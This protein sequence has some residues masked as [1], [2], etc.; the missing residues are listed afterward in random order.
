MERIVKS[1]DYDYAKLKNTVD[2]LCEKYSV[3]QKS[4]IGK[5]CAGRDI[6]A[7]KTKNASEY[8]LFAAAFHGSEHITSNVLLYF[9]EEFAKI[10]TENGF[11]AGIRLKKALGERGVIFVPCV[12]P[13]GC[14]ISVNKA[15]GCGKDAGRIYKL[16]KGDFEHW[17]SNFRGVD[18]N[19]NFDADWQKLHNTEQRSGIFGPSPTRFGG[20]YPESE[21]ETAAI[22]QLCK[23]NYIRH[24]VALHSQGEVIYWSF[25]GYETKTSKQMAE[26]M[27]A[28]SGYA[29]DVPVDI[30]AGGGFKDWF[31][32]YFSRPAFTVE[33]GKGTNPLPI[34]QASEIYGTLR[35]MLTVC[36]IM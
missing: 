22:I 6:V 5:S 20:E 21:P 11:M 9:M 15:L 2:L 19:H 31:M 8:V 30:A 16:S 32:Q 12:N 13:D 10:Y 24:A 23:N 27:A 18:I 1:T 34:S 4:V 28:T 7:L 36:S 3:L 25:N 35:E 26:I 17:N 29:L 33:I 14:E